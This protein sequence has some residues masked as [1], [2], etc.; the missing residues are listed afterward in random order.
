M[1]ISCWIL[2]ICF[3][4]SSLLRLQQDSA[5]ASKTVAGTLQLAQADRFVDDVGM[6][7]EDDLGS[8]PA[9]DGRRGDQVSHPV[10]AHGGEIQ[11]GA[12]TV[13]D[14]TSGFQ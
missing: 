4:C 10:G 2:D 7:G 12:K 3:P 1:D 9:S 13:F 5:N 14:K 8:P 11:A 6:T